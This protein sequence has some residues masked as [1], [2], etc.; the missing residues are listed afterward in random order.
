M[1]EIPKAVAEQFGPWGYVISTAIL[2]FSVAAGSA[3]WWLAKKLHSAVCILGEWGREIIDSHKEYL[4]KT[5]ERL[6]KIELALPDVCAAKGEHR[7]E[8][9]REQEDD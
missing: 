5:D 1:D 7:R 9:K 8:R 6:A 3:A 2:T 4:A